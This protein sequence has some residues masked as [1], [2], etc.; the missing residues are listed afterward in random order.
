[1]MKLYAG[2]RGRCG[3]R[4]QELLVAACQWTSPVVSSVSA[5]SDSL[6]GPSDGEGNEGDEDDEG[7]EG[8]HLGHRSVEGAVREMD[9]GSKRRL[10]ERVSGP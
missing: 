1:M 7:D 5:A 8:W 2:V 10:W 9:G 3:R 6:L 4:E